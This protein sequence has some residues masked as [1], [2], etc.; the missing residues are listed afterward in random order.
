MAK[1]LMH[2][3]R[4]HRMDQKG[5]APLITVAIIVAVAIAVGYVLISRGE[6]P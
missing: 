4:R 1:K 6:G 2:V 5:L 3:T